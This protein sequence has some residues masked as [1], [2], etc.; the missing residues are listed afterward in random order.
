MA[1]KIYSCTPAVTLEDAME[2]MKEAQVRRLPIV[3]EAGH[4]DLARGHRSRGEGARWRLGAC[5]YRRNVRGHH[6]AAD[7]SG[8]SPQVAAG[9]G[10]RALGAVGLGRSSR[11]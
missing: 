7:H 10:A 5:G 9:V 2:K 6:R 8:V 3:D 11:S 4:L 1:R